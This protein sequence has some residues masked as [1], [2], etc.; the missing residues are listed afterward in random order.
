M[1]TLFAVVVLGLV[2]GCAHGYE[3]FEPPP[4]DF[5]DRAPIRLAVDR[6]SIEST[7]ESQGEPFIEHTLV[8]TPEE[9]ARRLLEHR[10]EAVG[11]PGAMRAVIQDASVVEEALETETGIRGWLT[12]EAAARLRGNL[13]VRVER[14]DEQGRVTG[15][16]TTAVTRTTAILEDTPYARRQELAYELVLDLVDDLD[17][18]LIA[19][20]E[21]NFASVIR[22]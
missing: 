6:V 11:G 8:L 2:V 19:N 18:G 16:I 7:Y 15:S 10:L 5:G 20:I 12:T 17:A 21:E 4:L 13:R 22:P 14:L 1:R 9:A 3:S